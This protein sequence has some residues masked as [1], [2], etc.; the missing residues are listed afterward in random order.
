MNNNSGFF[1]KLCLSIILFLFSGILSAYLY[2]RFQKTGGG[3]I[4]GLIYTSATVFIFV[5]TRKVPILK[6]LLTYYFLMVLTYVV[7]WLVS[8]LT[9]WF[10]VVGGILTAGAGAVI[11]FM[12]VNRF[13]I[14]IKYNKIVLFIVG[15]LAF[16]IT[17]I[18]YYI[19]GNTFDKTPVEYLFKIDQPPAM[20]FLEVFVFW[21]TMV[22]TKLFLTMNN[23]R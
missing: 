6:K 11:T 20:L 17:D 10:I 1:L 8:F 4:P 9:S 23:I 22:G 15:G 14:P 21:Q 3:L 12:L 18:L 2:F 5:L 7:I 16:V 13:I 19:F